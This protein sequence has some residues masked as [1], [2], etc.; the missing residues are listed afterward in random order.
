M[1]VLNQCLGTAMDWMRANKL[2]LNPDKMELLLAGDSSVQLG[3]VHPVLEGVT[4][5]L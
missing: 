3:D 4:L 1:V 5:P 2:R